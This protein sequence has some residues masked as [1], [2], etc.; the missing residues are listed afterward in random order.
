MKQTWSKL[1]DTS[2]TCIFNTF[3]ACLLHVCFIV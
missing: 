2:C 3:A 1:K